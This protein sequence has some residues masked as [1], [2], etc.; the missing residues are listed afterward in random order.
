[1]NDIYFAILHY[2]LKHKI[3]K[4]NT[5]TLKDIL[6]TN[7]IK[8]K[9]IIDNFLNLYEKAYNSDI[10]SIEYLEFL[11][12]V[13]DFIEY[14]YTNYTNTDISLILF[15]GYSYDELKELAKK[16][17]L[18][19]KNMSYG[20]ENWIYEDNITS[21]KTGLNIAEEMKELIKNL[22]NNNIDVYVVS[23]SSRIFVEV[24]LEPIKEYITNIYGMELLMENGIFKG[25]FDKNHI[26]TL[27]QGKVDLINQKIYP[28]YNKGPILVA[29]DNSGDYEMLTQY[30]DT[31]ISLL[32]DRNRKN[33]FKEL[34][35]SSN[36]KY[37][38]LKV[39]EEKGI[40]I[41]SD[42]SITI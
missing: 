31:K 7:F 27:G 39:D 26:L 14:F 5:Q 42:K 25:L 17:I 1:M 13:E 18:Y 36:E 24:M 33:K 40:F 4:P 8:E 23:A 22:H 30:P 9:E 29:G 12:N 37:L 2:I 28:K 21:L 32:V 10:N 6:Y 3:L 20:R 19:H 34:I 11:A 41:N 15:T 16:A 35:E 38:V